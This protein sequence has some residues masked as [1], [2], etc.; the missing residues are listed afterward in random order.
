MH[1]ATTSH[2]SSYVLRFPEPLVPGCGRF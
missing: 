1:E 2:S